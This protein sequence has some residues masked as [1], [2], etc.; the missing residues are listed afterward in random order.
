MDDMV[1]AAMKKW[2][3]VPA[4]YGWLGL[5]AKGDWYMRDDAAQNAGPFGEPDSPKVA[6]GARLQH[7]GLIEFI[8]RNYQADAS[9]CW[10]FQNGPQKVYVD[11]EA[12]PWVLHFDHAMQPRTHLGRPFPIDTVWTD[13]RELVY[14][15]HAGELAVVR[16]QDMA[17]F[18]DCWEKAQWPLQATTR[19]DLEKNFQFTRHP[20][21]KP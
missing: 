12:A 7:H 11:L 14:V 1:K 5:D 3:N 18:A 15:S 16:S 17:L 4:C 6:K 9:G 8:K 13:E 2:P 20:T 19:S 10:Y 21:P